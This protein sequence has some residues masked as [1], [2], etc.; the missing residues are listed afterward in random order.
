M[1]KVL[2]FNCSQSTENFAQWLKKFKE[3]DNSLLLEVDLNSSSFITKSYTPQDRALV[4]WSTISFENAGFEFDSIREESYKGKKVKDEDSIKEH[5]IKVGI[6]MILDKF[7][8]VINTFSST[9]FKLCII[10]DLNQE[11]NEYEAVGI[12]LMSKTLTMHVQ[13]S[14]VSEFLEITD[15]MFNNRIYVADSPVKFNVTAETVKNLL[16]I[17]SV[18]SIDQKKDIMKF[19]VAKNDGKIQLF[20]KDDTNFSY[21][22]MLAEI[23][24]FEGFKQTEL[25]VY[26][27]KFIAATKG[28]SDDLIVSMS[29]TDPS[30]LI[31]DSKDENTKTVISVVE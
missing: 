8:N 31:I 18:F 22:Y 7:I 4:R 24:D 9:D 21:D 26:A 29:M 13:C 23:D 15:S 30:R 28:N 10:F 19:Y 25:K 20:A 5:R 27:T 17:S 6:F 11:S 1:T 12:S 16:S 2:V 3:I 14:N